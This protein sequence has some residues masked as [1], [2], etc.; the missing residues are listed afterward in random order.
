MT[1]I[2][3]E[4]CP[5]P[6]LRSPKTIRLQYKTPRCSPEEEEKKKDRGEVHVYIHTYLCQMLESIRDTRKPNK[7]H[8][9]H[10]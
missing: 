3:R 1:A 5:N 8:I 9:I 4:Q 7:Q 6:P 10:L 2:I